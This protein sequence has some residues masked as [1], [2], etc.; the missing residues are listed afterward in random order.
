MKTS[1]SFLLLIAI[2]FVSV[3]AVADVKAQAGKLFTVD[4]NADT[5]DA[6]VGDGLCRDADGRCTL[7]AA[8]QEANANS[9]QDAVNFALPMPSTIDLTLGELQI[10]SNI[11]IVGPGARNL[12]VQRSSAAGTPDFRVFH[13]LPNAGT[14]ITI[15]GFKVGNGKIVGNGGGIYVESGNNNVNLLDLSVNGNTATSGG[16]VANAGN[17][18]LTRSLISGN[19]AIS[20]QNVNGAGAGFYGFANSTAIISNSTL[21]QN[22]A[23]VGGSIYNQGTLTL[24]NNTISHNNADLFGCSIVSAESGMINVL[25]TIIGMDNSQTVSSLW[26]AFTSLG[27]NLITDAR[28]STGFTNGVNNDQV[29]DNNAIN[30]LIGNLADNGG[31][32]DTRALLE[33]S[34]AINQGNNCVYF[35]N[36]VQPLQNFYLSADQR[37]NTLR[38]GGPTVDIGAF[39][40]QTVILSAAVAESATFGNRTRLGGILLILTKASTNEKTYRLTNPFGNFFIRNL[41]RQEVYILERRGKRAGTSALLIFD[42]DFPPIPPQNN[43]V[44]E[45]DGIRFTFDK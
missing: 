10:T 38:L 12:T 5:N 14:L 3:F 37:R 42:F 2:L 20:N 19:T 39:E 40:V 6:N 36:C 44:I 7:R 29:S 18:N 8:I 35:N 32:T 22:N 1:K 45:Q 16:G 41:Q 25:N 15:R 30:P 24:V 23:V 9:F 31:Q 43:S 28:N 27:N 17:L 13:I 34:P 26:G 33:G 21:T 4:H 11:Y